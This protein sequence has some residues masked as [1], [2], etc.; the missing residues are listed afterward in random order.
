MPVNVSQVYD[1]TEVTEGVATLVHLSR[2][3]AITTVFAPNI[4]QMHVVNH[5]TGTEH[6]STR[7]CLEEAARIARGNIEA[8]SSL[9]VDKFDAVIFPGRAHI[10]L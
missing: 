5:T 7:N 8:L 10:S 3:G 4:D 6:S 9:E 1:G 2:A